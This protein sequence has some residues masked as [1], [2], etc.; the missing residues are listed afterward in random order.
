MRGGRTGQTKV[1]H[2]QVA[3]GVQ[4]QI[5]GLQVTVKDVGRVHGLERSQGLVNEV[6]AVIVGQVLGADDT[7][8]VSLHQF[9]ERERVS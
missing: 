7:V 5:R 4:K 9:L 8:H 6:L 3:V 2:F 1:A